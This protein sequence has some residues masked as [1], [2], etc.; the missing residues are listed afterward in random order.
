MGSIIAPAPIDHRVEKTMRK[1]GVS[2]SKIQELWTLFCRH[3]QENSEGKH[4]IPINTFLRDILNY[5]PSPLTDALPVFF[6]TQAESHLVFGEFVEIVCQFCFFEQMDL[7]RYIF[8]VLDSGRMGKVEKTVFKHFF[9]AI[10]HNKPYDSLREAMEY[11]DTLDDSG[12]YTYKQFVELRNTYPIIFYPMYA[13]QNAMISNT[14]G[15]FFWTHH[16]AYYWDDQLRMKQK[17]EKLQLKKL[18]EQEREKNKDARIHE[19]MV[20]QRMGILFYLTPWRRALERQ[21]IARIAAWEDELDRMIDDV[22][23]ESVKI[24]QLAALSKGQSNE[25]S[26]K[27]L[28]F[29]N[30]NKFCLFLRKYHS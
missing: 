20:M 12:F 26:F 17:F 16:K 23:F 2:K 29:C 9:T 28:C 24:V 7:L 4:I 14:L 19:D 25:N 21:R 1:F 18:K 27:K 10:W 15:E 22:G 30:L 5:P 8:N 3:C 11:L 13:F 6:D